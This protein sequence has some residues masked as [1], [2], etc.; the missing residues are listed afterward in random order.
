MTIN[1]ALNLGI[2]A[3]P[4]AE[5]DELN[6]ELGLVYNALHNI[7]QALNDAGIPSGGGGSPSPDIADVP[8]GGT[9]VQTMS[10]VVI[11]H[12]Q[13]PVVPVASAV[14]GKLL[15]YVGPGQYDY[16]FVDGG[17]PAT[18]VV[19][20]DT[21]TKVQ[22]NIYG[23]VIAGFDAVLASPDYHGQ[24]PAGYF[25]HGNGITGDPTWVPIVQGVEGPQGPQ[26]IQG[27][28]GSSV[29]IYG[30]FGRITVPGDL[31]PSG[32]IPVDFDGTGYP[33]VAFQMPIGG[34]LVYLGADG[35]G[36]ETNDIYTF[37]DTGDPS[38][39]TNVGK[40]Q[41][42]QGDQGIQGNQGIQGVTGPTGPIGPQGIAGNTGPQGTPGIQ[43]IQGDP[44]AEGPQGIEG[45]QGPAGES[46]SIIGY[47]GLITLPSD[48]PPD[49]LIPAN[50]DGP[51]RPATSYQMLVGQALTYSPSNT[52]NPL[53]GHLYNYVG[54]NITPLGWSDIGA[55]GGPQGQQGIQGIQGDIG[56][57]GPQ[58][59]Q[60]IQGTQGNQGVIGNQGPQGI[61]GTQGIQGDQGFQGNPGEQGPA[62]TT[63]VLIGQIVN[64]FASELPPSGLIPAD[65][66]SPGYPV[67]DY[68]MTAG[69]ALIDN[70]PLD[71]GNY[72]DV[73]SFVTTAET[74]AGWVNAGAI[75]GPQGV[76]GEQGP[77]G[78]QGVPGADGAQGIQGDQG[79]PGI[80]GPQGIQGIQ[81]PP[82]PQGEQGLQ[83]PQGE[84][85]VSPNLNSPGPIGST[86]SCPILYVDQID[87]TAQATIKGHA[88]FQ[89]YS[90][91]TLLDLFPA[92][93]GSDSLLR[94]LNSSGADFSYLNIQAGLN[95]NYIETLAGG[96]GTVKP[97]IFNIGG[98]GQSAV[99]GVDR[100]WTFSYN[101]GVLNT[102]PFGGSYRG[103]TAGATSIMGGATADAYLLG[104]MY[105]DG[106]NYRYAR[107]GAGNTL[108]MNL[109][110]FQ[111]YSY[112]A[113]N[114][115]DVATGIRLGDWSTGGITLAT[116]TFNGN[117]T[118]IAGKPYL[119]YQE[120]FTID[121]DTQTPNTTGFT[122]SLNAPHTGPIASVGGNAYQ[123]QMNA[124]YNSGGA[125]ISFRTYQGDA[126]VWNPWYSFVTSAN[127]ASQSVNYAASATNVTSGGTV[128][129]QTVYADTY[130]SLIDTDAIELCYQLGSGVLVIRSGVGYLPFTAGS[131]YATGDV[132]AFSDERVKRNWRP[133]CSDFI[134]Q[135]AGLKSGIFDRT[136]KD[137]T[138]VGV[139]AQSL[140]KFM[141]EAVTITE[142]HRNKHGEIDDCV[143]E[144][145]GGRLA[146]SYGNA[147]M[148]SAVELAKVVI[149]LQ[150]EVAE[151][152]RQLTNINNG[153]ANL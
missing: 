99:M 59:I 53:W 70:N 101:I 145:E 121:A 142:P 45:I 20:A 128:T 94:L 95:Y 6:Y 90:G 46:T 44:G 58:G 137:I 73:Y 61:Q 41:G 17:I 37:V 135:L 40:L 34:G 2:P 24:G 42:P 79:E 18:P 119:V 80:Q 81:G 112:P 96:A 5:N 133:V 66:E 117:A 109:G 85:G 88:K 122:Y 35:I 69:Q 4:L 150:E 38:G 125:A 131:V 102:L 15:A 116:G 26:G 115:D 100:G 114:V 123:L 75:Q 136:D 71:T 130:N 113:G 27:L 30:S 106:T 139:G 132:T 82:G 60:G 39:W 43:G 55:I 1:S 86:T 97:L 63:A 118:G 84:Q 148:V 32:L 65:W 110:V 74:P 104:N 13:D 134:K 129:T 147:A 16:N 105:Y 31:P 28:D 146:V 76:P 108:S 50:F 22:Y 124:V 56:P 51:G 21:N 78:I 67:N 153:L 141:P 98:V 33:S 54:T 57:I 144:L 8:H 151:L 140:Q 62:G 143:P 12:G 29:V 68:Q 91:A 23:Q 47:F 14:P 11:G 83:G 25:L 149:A 77:Q 10:G 127:I 111:F 52:S 126:A 138:Q 48:L 49:G 19:S 89:A 64:R 87:L 3:V 9:G 120:S 7:Q 152:R 93:D 103:A 107:T 92:S 36:Y 72:G